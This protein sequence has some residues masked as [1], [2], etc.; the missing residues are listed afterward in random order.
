MRMITGILIGIF[1]AWTGIGFGGPIQNMH[2]IVAKKRTGGGGPTYLLNEGF[3]GDTSA[4]TATP[5]TGG[6]AN[7]AYTPALEG[8][9]SAR[10]MESS[11][12]ASVLVSLPSTYNALEG[13]FEVYLPTWST[14]NTANRTLFTL[15][16][17]GGTTLGAVLITS[18]SAGTVFSL[19]A[20]VV[21]TAGTTTSATFGLTTKIYVWWY[22]DNTTDTMTVL[23]DTTNT[24]PTGDG[25]KTA[26]ATATVSTLVGKV[27]GVSDGPNM[28]H[29]FDEIK[30][31]EP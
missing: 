7:L 27:R 9:F 28:N 22:W 5:G 1:L 4:W 19:N 21:S 29:V 6:V 17:T 3:E 23:W 24:E 30:V 15:E 16:T 31:W 25:T 26:T 18:T 2:A 12:D 11:G 10:V 8:S 13:S 14:S 20:K